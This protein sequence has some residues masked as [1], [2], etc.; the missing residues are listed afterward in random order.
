MTARLHPGSLLLT[1][2]TYFELRLLHGQMPS[3]DVYK[4][5]IVLGERGM[6]ALMRVANPGTLGV[7][8]MLVVESAFK[9]QYFFAAPM[10]VR[11]ES[12][13]RRRPD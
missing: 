7:A 11:I 2:H 10:P 4:S 5:P 9:H 12:G 6:S 8:A 3:F 13:F 1:D